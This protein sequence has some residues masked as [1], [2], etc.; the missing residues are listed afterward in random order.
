M[1]KWA[2]DRLRGMKRGPDG[3]PVA[4]ADVSSDMFPFCVEVKDQ[5]TGELLWEKTI[6]AACVVQVPGFAPRKVRCTVTYLRTGKWVSTNS[7]GE[8]IEGQ[9]D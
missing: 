9:H 2:E 7:N 6:Y 4:Y 1:N 3:L 5:E 8:T